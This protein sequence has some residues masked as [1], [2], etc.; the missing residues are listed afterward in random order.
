MVKANQHLRER[1]E[2]EEGEFGCTGR[3]NKC[4]MFLYLLNLLLMLLWLAKH[5]AKK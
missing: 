2:Y 5:I 4:I 1:K 3:A